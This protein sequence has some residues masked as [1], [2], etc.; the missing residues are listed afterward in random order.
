MGQPK[1][2][3]DTAC[4][5]TDTQMERV[6][7]ALLNVAVS[8]D[9]GAGEAQWREQGRWP[10]DLKS[11][12]VHGRLAG[13]RGGA[14]VLEVSV[15]RAGRPASLQAAKLMPYAEAVKE[16]EAYGDLRA[17]LDSSLYVPVIAVSRAVHERRGDEIPCSVVVYRH[18]SAW[19]HVPGRLESLED[20]V[21]DAVASPERLEECTQALARVLQSLSVNLYGA[22]RCEEVDLEAENQ[23]L[24]VDLHLRVDKVEGS[25]ASLRL[26][27]GNPLSDEVFHRPSSSEVLRNA[28]SPP[29]PGRSLT[30]GDR[31]EITLEKIVT[32]GRSVR[33]EYRSSR[34]RVELDGKASQPQ[35]A[36]KLRNGHT[37]VVQGR[38]AALRAQEWSDS[39]E[40]HF[41][42]SDTFHEDVA[43]QTL[44]YEGVVLGHPL[45]ALHTLL[46][47]DAS[48]RMRSPAHG[49]LNPRNVI[50]SGD[51]PFL[52]DFA[53]F[54]KDAFTFEDISWLEMCILRDCVARRLTFRDVVLLQRYLGLLTLLRPHWDEQS[55][56]SA[57]ASFADILS[58]DR[59]VLGRCLLILWQVRCGIWKTVPDPC[60]TLWP[61]HYLEHL[62]LS[63][64]RT[65][66]WPSP[67]SPER[68]QVSAAAA[69]VA[70]EFLSLDALLQHWSDEDRETV[71]RVLVASDRG[72][73]VTEG[74]LDAAVATTRD[75]VLRDRVLKRLSERPLREALDSIRRRYADV[76]PAD[77]LGWD[78]STYISLEGRQLAPGEPYVQQG[79]G[80]LTL[81]ARGCLELLGQH[82]A[83]IL[84]A[85]PGGGKSRIARELRTRHCSVQT[86][87]APTSA[88][89]PLQATALQIMEFLH[90]QQGQD[91]T[92]VRFLLQLADVGEALSE[93]WLE[94][95]IALG[96]VH[97]T[98]DDLHVVSER[99]Q[100]SI[101]A[102]IKRL[103]TQL[104]ELR[105]LV[106][107]RVGDFHPDV[108]RWPTVVVHKVRENAARSYAADVLRTHRAQDWRQMLARLENRLF[109]DPKAAALRDLA[110]KPQFLRLLVQH[111]VETGE[112]PANLGSLV[113]EYLNRLLGAP[114][115]DSSPADRRLLLLGAVAEDLG[116]AGSLSRERAVHVLGNAAHDADPCETAHQ[117]LASLLAT[118]VV[119]ESSDR[120]SFRYPL[121]QSYCAAMAL[122]RYPDDQ[123]ARVQELILRHGWRETAVLLVADERSRPRTVV[124]V[125]KAGV[126]ASPWYGALLLQA[127]P[128]EYTQEV[129][130]PF[131]REQH[132]VLRSPYSGVPAW[133][134]S[135]YAL[136][137]YG[138]PEATDVLVK[139]ASASD[140]AAEAAQAALDG[141]VM[142]HQWSVPGAVQQLTQVTAG[143]LE[144]TE[145]QAGNSR[146]ARVVVGALRSVQVAGL[147]ELAGYVWSRVSADQPW[148]VLSQAW[149]ALKA[150]RLRPDRVRSLVYAEACQARLRASDRALR[151]TAD[152]ATAAAL[153]EERLGILQDLA[154]LGE[155]ESLLAYRFRAGLAECP[156]WGA[157]LQEALRARRLG[158]RSTAVLPALL[159][160]SALQAV[161]V[162]CEQWK[163]L[164]AV[165]DEDLAA[166]A[167]HYVL[168][169]KDV[170]SVEL[171]REVAAL[172]TARSLSVVAAFVHCLP[173]DGHKSLEQLLEPFLTGMDA[174]MVEAV[175]SFVGAA[176]TLHQDTGR[177]LALHVQNALAVQGLDQEALHWPWCTTWRLA[178]P[179]RAEMP[180]FLAEHR[181]AGVGWDEGP[182]PTLLSLLGSADVLLDAPYVKPVAL[183]PELRKRL[184]DLKPSTT[185]GVAAHQFVLLAASAGLPDELRFVRQVAVDEYN[186][187]T[188]IRHAHGRHGLVEVTLA[189]H[190][191]TAIGYLGMLAALEDPDLDVGVTT[192]MLQEM[193]R[194]T[195]DMHPSMERA[196]LIALG[197]FGQLAPLLGALCAREDPILAEAVRN[198][199]NHWLPGP[200]TSTGTDPYFSQVATTLA[201]ELNSK[202]LPPQTRALLTEL[203]IGIEDRLGRYVI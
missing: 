97:L 147:S 167:A 109:A 15:A 93:Q 200:R 170:V 197:Y 150:L 108:L 135:A 81:Q 25:G 189:A 65:F 63:A 164:L 193:G 87:T 146:D 36:G 203:R 154:A 153:N 77:D 163:R 131:L 111:F 136:A 165:G 190:A 71:A 107:Q 177:R 43:A 141:L 90:R 42:G 56:Q 55:L 161:G 119:I 179:P 100:R 194:L 54:T 3:F 39:L 155:V 78:D 8:D 188:V 94:R 139:V 201:E 5:L 174:D 61:Q 184:G 178:L 47:A 6:K 18:V 196:R 57:A 159:E 113:R 110:G 17:T 140:S 112:V 64:C 75:G 38:L 181:R 46:V 22:A 162:G 66:K 124:N 129:R 103:R 40:K 89:L 171:L 13:G 58:E 148:E 73:E 26:V 121:V 173:S 142:M 34:V 59:P 50:L 29:G 28:T 24:G 166:L 122:Q 116:S 143:L 27:D 133:K 82:P 41:G 69:G 172:G 91:R 68:V 192:E 176:E 185:D 180:L 199:V 2:S 49:D 202:Q 79:D 32:E 168:A 127:A 21:A 99:D 92:V 16:W 74:L 114:P 138:V 195:G 106:C 31:A 88:L 44:H 102:W 191:V 95:L 157:M 9:A 52:I 118:S 130:V 83:V 183:A 158:A 20:L 128:E 85:E 67:D 30:L 175:A 60:R 48:E 84:L 156:A 23:R 187:Q 117:V 152:T 149:Q 33:G 101:L 76:P 12:L 126:E 137:K 151:T 51:T 11:V 53:T 198:I 37:V 45:A 4:G 7:D 98:I 125:V 182:D 160:E 10:A 72:D 145:Q 120:V 62:V 123:L 134:R 169:A 14:D 104:P 1:I 70:S 80:A 105:L 186:V 144:E 96:A 86:G 115:A 132:E 19:D 35:Q